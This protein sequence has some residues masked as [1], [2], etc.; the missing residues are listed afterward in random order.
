MKFILTDAG[1]MMES[2]LVVGSKPIITRIEAGDTYSPNPESLQSVINKKQLL[3]VE[4]ID[5]VDGKSC[6]TFL[7]T[8]LE[9]AEEYWVKQI[10]IYAKQNEGA[11]EILYLIGQDVTGELVPAPEDRV[12]EYIYKLNLATDNAYD[13]SFVVNI[14]DF[15]RKQQVLELERNKVNSSGGDISETVTMVEEPASI[16]DKY[17]EISGKGSIKTVLGKLLRWTKS[18]KEDKVNKTGG[19][20]ASTKVASLQTSTVQYPVPA[21]GDTTKVVIGKI[22]KFFE[23]IRN[24]ATGACYIG[25]IVNNCVTNRTDL[26]LSAAQGKVLMDLYNVL[27][28]KVSSTIPPNKTGMIY[29]KDD[30]THWLGFS[31]LAYSKI[32]RSILGVDYFDNEGPTHFDFIPNNRDTEGNKKITNL[33]VDYETSPWKLV[34]EVYIDGRLYKKYFNASE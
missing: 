6:I 4:T 19:D 33:Y 10:G 28:A 18:L 22:K 25:Q 32:G 17:P 30:R 31:H 8:N 9:L 15:A 1:K 5:V 12:V 27:N 34:V 2:Q 7:L 26:P 11:D 23:D 14:T 13:M 29:A 20:I 3:Q 24:T 16:A 21:A